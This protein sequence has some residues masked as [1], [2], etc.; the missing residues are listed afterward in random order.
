MEDRNSIS[1]CYMGFPNY[2]GSFT[3]ID[4]PTTSV[5]PLTPTD[6]VEGS[7]FSLACVVEDI[8][9]EPRQHWFQIPHFRTHVL[10]YVLSFTSVD[11]PRTSVQPRTSA[12]PVEG[13]SFSL[14]CVVE[15][16]RPD[17]HEY[18]WRKDGVLV[19]ESGDTLSLGT[20]NR[21]QDDGEYTCSG[22]NTAG[23]GEMSQPYEFAVYCKYIK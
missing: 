17:P 8:I 3:T 13:T 23:M 20:L 16:G 7:S 19:E 18:L 22:N 4:K 9:P 2:L 1:T 15:D 10:N 12:D 14:A 6:P 21:T 11:K 5:Q